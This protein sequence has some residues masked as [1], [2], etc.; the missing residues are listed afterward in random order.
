MKTLSSCYLPSV[1]DVRGLSSIEVC[2][3]RERSGL[4]YRFMIIGIDKVFNQFPRE[5]ECVKRWG[6][7]RGG[8]DSLEAGV[9]GRGSKGE[10][11][12]ADPENMLLAQ[13]PRENGV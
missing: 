1:E 4:G 7:G 8:G 10:E 5:S 12:G 9:T 2:R 11:R 3:T 6:T 13:K